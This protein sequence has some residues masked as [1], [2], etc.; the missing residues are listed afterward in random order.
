MKQN[1]FIQNNEQYS[2]DM[3]RDVN[4]DDYNQCTQD[5]VEYF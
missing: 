5:Q 2:F 1:Y 3:L 4:I